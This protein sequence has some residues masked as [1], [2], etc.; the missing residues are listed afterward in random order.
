MSA[1]TPPQS[2]ACSP[3]KSVSVSSANVVSITPARVTPIAFPY[4]NATP[5]ALPVASWCTASSAGVPAPSTNSSRTRCPGAFGAIIATSTSGRIVIMNDGHRSSPSY[6]IITHVTGGCLRHRPR[7]R[8]VTGGAACHR[9][10]A[11]SHHFHDA[12]GAQHLEQ[13]IDLVFG[14]RRL[15]HERLGTNV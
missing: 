2:T 10:P 8:P 6:R 1:L 13:T 7:C 9:D 4:D 5:F 12:V 15:D 11:G 3:N 14:A